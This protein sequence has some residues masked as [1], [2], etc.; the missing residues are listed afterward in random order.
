[1]A[2]SKK[3][4]AERKA[5][6]ERRRDREAKERKRLEEEKKKQLELPKTRNLYELKKEREKRGLHPDGRDDPSTRQVSERPCLG[7]GGIVGRSVRSPDG[8]S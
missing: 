5:V 1:M 8:R 4:A 2:Q 3:E 7:A 6:E